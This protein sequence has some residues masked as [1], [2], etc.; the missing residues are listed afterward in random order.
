MDTVMERKIK[1]DEKKCIHCGKCIND[2]L[3]GCLEFDENKIPRHSSLGSN[4]IACQHCMAIC[5]VGA[6]SFNGKNPENSTKVDYG[7]DV[8]L[9]NLI[10]SRKSIRA[11]KNENIPQE[12]FEKI[13]EMLPFVPTG[14]NINDLHFS[15]VETKEKMNEIIKLTYEK[16]LTADD[17][18]P[19]IQLCK[20][21]YKNGCDIIYRG[22]PSMIAVAVDTKKAIQGCE[23]A[24]PIIALSYLDLYAPTIG[25]GTLWCDMAL[26]MANQFPEIYS[27]LEI[28]E[29]Y[30]LNYTMLLGI[31]DVKY[32]RTAQP[33]QFS[34]K[35]I[36]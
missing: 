20:T 22:A 31:P 10:K 29:N 2:C 16:I 32:Q 27:L 26:V 12:K 17:N 25:L 36:R 15:I 8:E 3:F 35:E 21:S 13:K 28:P 30:T 33:E 18:L 23:N 6:F 9:L 5:P 11:Y 24:D 34:I 7:N 14:A 1:I 19:L 4:C